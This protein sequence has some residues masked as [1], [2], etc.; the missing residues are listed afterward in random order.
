MQR[1]RDS[2]AASNI[3]IWVISEKFVAQPLR[4]NIPEVVSM[5]HFG[6]WTAFTD[7]LIILC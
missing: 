3:I 2:S 4:L 7:A 1:I 5:V 6:E